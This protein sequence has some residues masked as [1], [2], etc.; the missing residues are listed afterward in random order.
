M[1]WSE[2]VIS[3]WYREGHKEEAWII[4]DDL[5]AA[6]KSPAAVAAVVTCWGKPR[7]FLCDSGGA[8]E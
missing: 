4:D 2:D 3:T 8:T 6:L 1:T 7:E 5:A